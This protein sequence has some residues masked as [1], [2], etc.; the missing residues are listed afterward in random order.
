VAHPRSWPAAAA[1]R[2]GS[3][4]RGSVC[5]VYSPMTPRWTAERTLDDQ[6]LHILK[7]LPE[8]E[9]LATRTHQPYLFRISDQGKFDKLT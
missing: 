9:N 6:M 4:L 2:V 7:T 1:A 3:Y 8:I 5:R